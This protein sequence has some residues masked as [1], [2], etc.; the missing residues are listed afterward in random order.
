MYRIYFHVLL[1]LSRYVKVVVERSYYNKRSAWGGAG[2][3][4]KVGSL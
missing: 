4:S 3:D 2:L 1:W